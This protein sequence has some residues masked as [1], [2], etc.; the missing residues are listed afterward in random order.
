[1]SDYNLEER[2]TITK[3]MSDKMYND[4]Y[5]TTEEELVQDADWIEAS[6]DV[7]KVLEGKEWSGADEDIAKQGL[8]AMSRFDFNLAYGTIGYTKK[9]SDAD[10]KAKLSF[11]YMMDQYEKKD[12][13]MNGVLRGLYNVGVD[14]SSYV[15]VATLGMSFFGKQAAQQTAKRGFK[16][17]MKQGAMRYLKSPAAV[18]ATEGAIFTASDDAAR[19]TSA[20]EAGVQEEFDLTQ[21]A[22]AGAVGAVAG[23]G[24]VKGGEKLAKGVAKG[25]KA[26]KKGVG[27]LYQEG[28]QEAIKAAG[29]GTPPRMLKGKL[30]LF[31]GDTNTVAR[32]RF[33]IQKLEK[34]SKGGSD[35]QVF[36]LG[37]NKVLK[38]AKTARGLSQN[39]A[40]S[41][42]FLA[43]NILPEIYESGK[44]YN[45]TEIVDFK[46]KRKE[47]NQLVKF[48][49]KQDVMFNNRKDSGKIY[50]ALIEAEE[51]FGVE[52]LSDLGNYDLLW[53]DI[54]ASRNWGVGKDGRIVLADGG[55]VS[56]SILDVTSFDKQ[57]WEQI[58]RTIK[59]LKKEHGD[60]DKYIASLGG[61]TLITTS[62]EDN[63]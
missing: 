26:I 47:I 23:A 33:D 25:A 24:L 48:L 54:T 50:N 18:A 51:K 15:G 53:G 13:S 49:Q 3:E 34:I 60:I 43:G 63:E 5:S 31:D 40:E 58:K 30:N 21:T 46:N 17:L 55:S 62:Q 7:Y 59:Q 2:Q 41:D 37:E 52:G 28:E 14:P 61:T 10:D 27:E 38:V 6:K 42:Y 22:V 19:Q 35:R 8:W 9:M 36:D 20:V 32:E 4:S 45:V 12:I 1:M 39:D 11:Y 56:E 44:N 57:E 16:E 29:G